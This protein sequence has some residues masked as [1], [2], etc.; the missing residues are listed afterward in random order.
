MKY[1]SLCVDASNPLNKS[2]IL[3]DYYPCFTFIDEETDTERNK[4]ACL[5]WQKLVSQDLN[6]DNSALKPVVLTTEIYFFLCNF[7]D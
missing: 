2:M 7:N 4:A 6:S 3:I 1:L 5:R